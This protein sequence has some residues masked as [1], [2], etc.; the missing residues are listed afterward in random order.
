MSRSASTFSLSDSAK[1]SALVQRSNSL[2]HA[3]IRYRV[4][5]CIRI[6]CTPTQSPDNIPF[7]NTEP[8]IIQPLNHNYYTDVK[9]STYTS[10]LQTTPA[11]AQPGLPIP[12]NSNSLTATLPPCTLIPVIKNSSKLKN[13]QTKSSQQ[14]SRHLSSGGFEARL[15]VP[16]PVSVK[17]GTLSESCRDPQPPLDTHKT[18]LT[19]PPRETLL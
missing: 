7:S 8:V 16:N 5:V 19:S 15:P 10:P 17:P 4:P 6:P 11:Q 3:P 2:D 13:D 18:V 14:T 12:H 1:T 9:Q